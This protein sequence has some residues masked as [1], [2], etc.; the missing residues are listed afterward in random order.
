ML[1]SRPMPRS[2][3]GE[4]TPT[5]GSSSCFFFSSRRRHTR[6]Q[7]DWS[8]DVCSSDLYLLPRDEVVL[9]PIDNITAEALSAEF[10]QRFLA[11]LKLKKAL[12][13]TLG[14]EVKIEESDRKSVV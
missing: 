14:I 10:C 11:K 5:T 12:T 9:L 1:A 4:H 8:S 2:A 6:L 13:Q 3:S 7:G